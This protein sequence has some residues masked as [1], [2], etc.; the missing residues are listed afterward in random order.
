MILS[1]QIEHGD[2]AKPLLSAVGAV[3]YILMLSEGLSSLLQ[4]R[5]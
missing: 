4:L 5:A 3:Y 2:Y 1:E